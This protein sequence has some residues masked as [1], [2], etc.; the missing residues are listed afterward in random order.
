MAHYPGY[1]NQPWSLQLSKAQCN[2]IPAPSHDTETSQRWTYSIIYSLCLS[3]LGRVPMTAFS[4]LLVWVWT[5]LILLK[6]L[7]WK[8]EG[9]CCLVVMAKTSVSGTRCEWTNMSWCFKCFP[10]L[11]K[12]LRSFSLSIFTC[13]L[14]PAP[15]SGVSGH[16]EFCL[17][18]R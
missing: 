6:P 5:G 15:L 12:V 13:T 1:H 2:Q 17:S 11:L 14:S 4:S 7:R 3:P 18:R 10:I 8:W 16:A 9:V